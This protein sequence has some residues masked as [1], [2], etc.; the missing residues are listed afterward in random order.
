MLFFSFISLSRWSSTFETT[1]MSLAASNK[2]RIRCSVVWPPSD[3]DK[4]HSM[5]TLIGTMCSLIVVPRSFALPYLL[6]RKAIQRLRKSMSFLDDRN[7]HCA[8]NTSE[9]PDKVFLF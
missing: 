9:S 7:I 2:S 6:S 3:A 8:R 1:H 5:L 4:N